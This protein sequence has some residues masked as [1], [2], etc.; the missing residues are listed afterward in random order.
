MLWRTGVQGKVQRLGG[1]GRL[2]V[3]AWKLRAFWGAGLGGCCGEP[4]AGA[5]QGSG[6]FSCLSGR[7]QTKDEGFHERRELGMPL[8][9]GVCGSH[10][11]LGCG[12]GVPVVSGRQLGIGVL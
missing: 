4:R 2:R 11:G 8:A 7:G 10:K 5:V 9:A 1:A 3:G 6:I 12:D